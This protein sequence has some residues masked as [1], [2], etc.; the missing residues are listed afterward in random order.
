MKCQESPSLAPGTGSNF[1]PLPHHAGPH[2][3]TPDRLQQEGG[4][5]ETLSS[6]GVAGRAKWQQGWSAQGAP[7]WEDV[8]GTE[9]VVAWLGT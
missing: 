5:G 4:V 9:G 1:S 3:G 7:G 8:E 6:L 2:A